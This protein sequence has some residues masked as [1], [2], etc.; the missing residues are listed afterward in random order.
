IA[1]EKRNEYLLLAYQL[2]ELASRRDSGGPSSEEARDTLDRAVTLLLNAYDTAERVMAFLLWKNE[3]YREV[4]PSLYQRTKSRK[5]NA[6]PEIPAPVPAAA[7]SADDVPDEGP[8]ARV[9]P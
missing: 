1:P 9:A 8:V 5:V 2:T 7:L 4:V 6:P 3:A